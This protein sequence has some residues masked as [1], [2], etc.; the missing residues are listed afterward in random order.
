MDLRTGLKTQPICG[1]GWAGLWALWAL[2]RST[3]WSGFK[4][5]FVGG[6]WCLSALFSTAFYTALYHDQGLCER[7]PM[8]QWTFWPSLCLND[9]WFYPVRLFDRSIQCIVNW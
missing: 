9:A 5:P 1:L 2:R 4:S 3:H 8:S 7:A 6:S